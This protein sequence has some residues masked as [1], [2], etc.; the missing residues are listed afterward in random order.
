MNSKRMFLLLV[1]SLIFIFGC[2]LIRLTEKKKANILP[3]PKNSI[4]TVFLLLQEVKNH[5]YFGATKLFIINDTTLNSEVFYEL[6]DKIQ[7]L[8]RN[9][10]TREITSY[11]I[12]T[13]NLNEHLIYVEF[14]YL[15]EYFFIT[16]RIQDLWLIQNFGEKK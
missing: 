11:K 6:N 13:L 12:D 3:D 7:R 10:S 14:D 15:Y 1:F 8:G 2:E 16:K 4:G 5:N 9:I